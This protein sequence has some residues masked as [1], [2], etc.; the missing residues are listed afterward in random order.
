[1][2]KN[3]G[4]RFFALLIGAATN[5]AKSIF[6]KFC[7][8]FAGIGAPQLVIMVIMTAS[9]LSLACHILSL[10]CLRAAIINGFKKRTCPTLPLQ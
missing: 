7:I 3:K 6:E 9:N 10:F 8:V 5:F 1:M 4:E 2:R